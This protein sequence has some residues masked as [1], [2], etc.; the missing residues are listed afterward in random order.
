MTKKWFK[1]LLNFILI[2]AIV[3]NASIGYGLSLTPA[4]SIQIHDDFK[5]VWVATVLNLDYPAKG[6]TDSATLKK[7]ALEIID[8]AAKYGFNA[9]VLQVRPSAD[10]LYKSALYP[11][12]KYLTGKQGSAPTENF[13]PLAFW[14]EE[15]HKRGI[16][17]HAW[18]NPYR[19]TR[20]SGN[21]PAHDYTQLTS[22]HPA[23]KNP[24]WVVAHTDGN[25][26]FNPGVPEVIDHLIDSVVEIVENYDVDGIHFDDY[27]YPSTTFNDSNT[28]ALYGNGFSSI[29]D[30]RR[31][32]VNQLV[33]GVH[34]AIKSVDET[35]QFGISPFGIWANSK[36]HVSGSATNGLESYFSQYA[37]TKKWVTEGWVDYIAPQIYW[38]IGYSIADYEILTKWWH[39][40][41]KDTDVNLYI[42]HAA[43]RTGNQ[44]PT[45]PWYG[46]DEIKKQLILNKSYDSIKGSIFFRYTFFKD[47]P[48][49]AAIVSTEYSKDSLLP[50]NQKLTVG[51]P[52]KDVS[53]T[54][55]SYFLGGS[56]DPSK[57]LF[58]NGNEVKSRTTEGYFGVF[59]PLTMGENKFVF[60]QGDTQ[61]VRTINRTK[62]PLAPPMSKVEIVPTS[63]WP[64]SIRNL[65][66][67]EKVTLSC[68]APIGAV[69]SVDFNGKTYAL[70]PAVSTSQSSKPYATTYSAQ[71]TLPSPT[72][73][74]KIVNLGNPVYKMVYQ[75]KHYSEPSKE[76]IKIIM[77][78]TAYMATVIEDNVDTYLNASTSG[79]S[80]HTLIKGMKDY[81]VA[82]IGDFAKL[83]SGL[84]VKRQHLKISTGVLRSNTV[85][86]TAYKS[87]EKADEIEVYL[88]ENVVKS[89][90][91][92]DNVLT[93]TFYQTKSAAPITLPSTSMV[94]KAD[95]A[96]DGSHLS[97]KMTL[98]KNHNLSGYYLENINGGI[99]LVL[100]KKFVIADSQ[101]AQ[102]LKGVTIMIDP[103]H[104]GSD[105]GA[106]GLLGVSYPEKLVTDAQARALTLSLEKLGAKVIITR[107]YNQYMSP[108]ERLQISRKALPDLFISLHADSM[109]ETSDLNKISGFTVF[110]KDPI[111][112]QLAES[113]QKTF[114]EHLSHRNRGAK[115]MNYYVTRGTW[116]PSVLVEAGFMSNPMDFQ[117]LTN[118]NEQAYYGQLIA[119]IIVD[120]FKK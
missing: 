18:L 110:Y 39:N 115:V 76:A 34:D 82:E 113:I 51:R 63:T 66:A 108:Q 15:A 120:Y 72:G 79:G 48:A 19:I 47:N 33:L 89:V 62:S 3:F 10:A 107:N 42:G 54:S 36:N 60:Q 78:G 23:I 8:N 29:A 41:V 75:G 85:R 55:T 12:S 103:G 20:K 109:A 90:L 102:P 53:T 2:L 11:W 7:E 98:K 96:V 117:W 27:F 114:G 94:E 57:P 77:T 32:N 69:V 105:N 14:I 95:I 44:D 73:I 40:L 87:G 46:V 118:A 116:A 70:K 13:D 58:L 28:Y 106:I 22:T 49:L 74:P 21:E 1:Q 71:I 112:K 43:Y 4:E 93:V 81:V 38:H 68:R 56:S 52:Y 111:A 91:L 16:A 65:T 30:W 50:L 92:K 24:S 37:D 80:Q 86:R 61:Y 101:S 119:N 5:A 64:Q 9:I 84:W 100:R 6:T 45:S 26:Y 104:G 25:L 59:M 35:V 17:I 31:N 99:K 97:Y 83:S 88:T 67:G